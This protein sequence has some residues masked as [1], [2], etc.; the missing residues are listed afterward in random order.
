M[1]NTTMNCEPYK[2]V[3]DHH[4]LPFIGDTA[5]PSTS[6][7]ALLYHKT[8]LVMNKLKEMEKGFYSAGLARP[9]PGL[10]L[11]YKLLDPYEE[12]AE[13]RDALHHSLP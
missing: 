9:F 2:A 13:G 4:L 3:L 10:E 6:W 7:T 8:K 5:P 12:E 11:H 1:K